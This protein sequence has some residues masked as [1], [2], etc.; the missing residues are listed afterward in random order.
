MRPF[1]TKLFDR[2]DLA[3]EVHPPDLSHEV[4]GIAEQ[5]VDAV[6]VHRELRPEHL[7]FGLR[8]IGELHAQN[9]RKLSEERVDVALEAHDGL[10]AA[11]AA[12][13]CVTHGKRL[14]DETAAE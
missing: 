9:L 4:L 6:A 8:R 10:V 2:C 3:I 11:L 13:G 7:T 12:Q 1:V 14:Q 5:R